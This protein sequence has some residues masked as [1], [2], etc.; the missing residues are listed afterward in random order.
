MHQAFTSL[1]VMTFTSHFQ[2]GASERNA[3][4]LGIRRLAIARTRATCAGSW[5]SWPFARASDS[6]LAYASAALLSIWAEDT[7]DD[8]LCLRSMPTAPPWVVCTLWQ[9]HSAASARGRAAR[10]AIFGNVLISISIMPRP[11]A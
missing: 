1:L 11:R 10:F 7:S 6:T 2:P 9:A 3:A 8:M 5:L 4:V